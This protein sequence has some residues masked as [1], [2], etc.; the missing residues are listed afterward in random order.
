MYYSYYNIFV[1]SLFWVNFVIIVFYMYFIF[2]NFVIIVHCIIYPT[3]LLHVASIIMHF[4][5]YCAL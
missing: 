5:Y 1:K 3:S 4:D 2:C